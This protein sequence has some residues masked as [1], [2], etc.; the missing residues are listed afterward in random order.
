MNG[1][2]QDLAEIESARHDAVVEKLD[3]TSLLKEVA[4][5]TYARNKQI[6]S[7]C[8]GIVSQA[9]DAIQSHIATEGLALRYETLIEIEHEHEVDSEGD[10]DD[11]SE[12][13]RDKLYHALDEACWRI[14]DLTVEWVDTGYNICVDLTWSDDMKAEVKR[15]IKRVQ[16]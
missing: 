14:Q 5:S 1:E 2:N 8:A 9:A 10:E 6:A 13:I 15:E 7:V 3:A 16:S 11:H 4:A 12:R